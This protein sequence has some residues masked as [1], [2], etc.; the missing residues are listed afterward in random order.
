LGE[1]GEGGVEG[2]SGDERDTACAET[3]APMDSGGLSLRTMTTEP[4]CRAE[5]KAG[6][7]ETTVCVL[8]WVNTRGQTGLWLDVTTAAEAWLR[9]SLGP[10]RGDDRLRWGTPEPY[11]GSPTCAGAGAAHAS[12][13]PPV[14]SKLLVR[15]CPGRA[16]EVSRCRGRSQPIVHESL[17]S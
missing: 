9:R 1:G 7:G 3:T 11:T 10:R 12:P 8:R 14:E 13:A 6:G 17:A 16:E 2:G 15:G 5:N 4:G